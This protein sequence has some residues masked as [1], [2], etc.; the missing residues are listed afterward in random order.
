MLRTD[1]TKLRWLGIDMRPRWRRRV[2]VV[3]TYA[4]FFVVVWIDPRRSYA[5]VWLMA[6]GGVY[7]PMLNY[8]LKESV[9]AVSRWVVLG[10]ACLWA[11]WFLWSPPSPPDHMRADMWALLW[12]VGVSSLSYAKLVE[13]VWMRSSVRRWL[14]RPRRL[15]SLDEF[16]RHY[17][18]ENF[19]ALAEEQQIEV[20]RLERGNPL[21]EW[22]IG[23]SGRLPLVEDERM[24]HEDDRVRA[25][26]QRFMTWVLFCSAVAWN[27]ASVSHH[28][29]S[30]DSVTA[31]AWTLAA[32][33]FTLRQAI[34]LWSEE[35][36]SELSQEMK[37]VEEI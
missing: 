35:D 17:Y 19:A 31:W 29:F 27:V 23:G 11:A 4:A 5:L 33:G 32:L 21:G 2:A 7:F 14:R 12:I 16:A 1:V 10:V 36:P 25:Q 24:R 34:V 18:G 3:L 20:G 28:S 15:H 9:S 6:Y 30:T 26:A 13:P 37:L 22:V 8:A